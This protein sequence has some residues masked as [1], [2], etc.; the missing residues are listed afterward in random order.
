MADKINKKI[1][2][3][4]ATY[5]GQEFIEKQIRSI[6]EQSV[7]PYE[8]IISD[9]NS[10][11]NTLA[12]LKELQNNYNDIRFFISKNKNRIGFAKNFLKA[13]LKTSGDI[14]FLSDQD[15]IWSKDKIEN[16]VNVIDRFNCE[17]TFS[18]INFIDCD[19]NSIFKKY[20]FNSSVLF[21][22]KK[23]LFKYIKYNYSDL[24]KNLN[25]PGMTFAFKS[26]LKFDIEKIYNSYNKLN[27]L[28]YHDVLIS[29]LAVR[30]KPLIFINADLSSYRIHSNN[31]I[32][33]TGNSSFFVSKRINWLT[34]LLDNQK[35]IQKVE[36]LLNDRNSVKYKCLLTK[37]IG[38]TNL[39]IQNLKRFNP[40]SFFILIINTNYIN[41]LKSLIGDL[42]HIVKNKLQ[43]K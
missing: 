40:I 14:I 13:V 39:R 7:A 5:N 31:T 43:Q 18:N 37:Y 34:I 6:C 33:M 35:F 28:K 24:V 42:V 36:L 9:D 2:V 29:Y 19:G 22:L 3:A 1:S 32:G 17:L 8:I 12:I 20:E 21:N 16:A 41:G 23:R 25:L 10:N 15:D 38:I 26:D 11:D 4:I 30:N 27:D